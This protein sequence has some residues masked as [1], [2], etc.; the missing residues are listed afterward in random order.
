MLLEFFR[1]KNASKLVVD[2]RGIDAHDAQDKKWLEEEWTPKMVELGMR[3]NALVHPES[4]VSQMEM[5]QL[6]EEFDDMPYEPLITS[7]L[8]EARQWIASK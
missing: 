5:E 4:V 7:S 8:S 2:T 3:H 1:D 6:M